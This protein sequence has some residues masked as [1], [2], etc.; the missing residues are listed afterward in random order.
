ML[1]YATRGGDVGQHDQLAFV[2]DAHG[3][4]LLNHT[5]HQVRRLR[6]FTHRG[7]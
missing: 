6:E 5:I 4:H 2:H 7:P 3:L 1:K